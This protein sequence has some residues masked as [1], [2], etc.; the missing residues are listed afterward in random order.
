LSR[1]FLFILRTSPQGGLPVSETL[2]MVL[3]LSAFDQVVDILYLDDG[4]YQLKGGQSGGAAFPVIGQLLETLEL[5][6]VNQVWVEQESMDERG[7]TAEDLAISAEIIRRV[8]VPFL[9]ARHDRVV[10]D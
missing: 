4:V 8:E 3:T 1:H 9:M 5:Y 10:G 6:G 2:D 7:M